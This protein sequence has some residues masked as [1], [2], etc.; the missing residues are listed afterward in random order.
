[1]FHLPVCMQE[2]CACMFSY[3][4]W[5]ERKKSTTQRGVIKY[6]IIQAENVAYLY[7]SLESKGSDNE[8]SFQHVLPV[9]NESRLQ[10]SKNDVTT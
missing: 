3:M 6:I 7:W 4:C 9:Y 8:L 10:L 1:M 5:A 2:K